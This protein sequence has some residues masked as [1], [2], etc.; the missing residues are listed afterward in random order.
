M[1]S[2]RDIGENRFS[3]NGRTNLHISQNAQGCQCDIIQFLHLD[4]FEITKLQ[5]HFVWTLLHALVELSQ[6]ICIFYL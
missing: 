5:K 6:T 1:P 4:I 2:H 3:G